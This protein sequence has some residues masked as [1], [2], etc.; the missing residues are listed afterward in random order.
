[1]LKKGQQVQVE[2]GWD[3]EVISNP[4]LDGDVAVM[5]TYK[6]GKTRVL[7]HNA[8]TGDTHSNYM[9]THKIFW[10]EAKSEQK[11]EEPPQ[12]IKEL[13]GQIDKATS[14]NERDGLAARFLASEIFSNGFPCEEND[15]VAIEND[16]SIAFKYADAF[17]KK[18]KEKK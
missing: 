9:P 8:T 12:I 4:D 16:V 1:M 15:S 7:M 6:E 17:L 13:I 14:R 5:H 11:E 18:S 2:G 3:V 10:P